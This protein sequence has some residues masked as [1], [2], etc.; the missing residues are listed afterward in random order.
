MQDPSYGVPLQLLQHVHLVCTRNFPIAHQ[1]LTQETI[2]NYLRQASQLV[3]ERAPVRWEYWQPPRDGSVFLVWQPQVQMGDN[4]ASDGYVWQEPE[5]A[6]QHS[7]GG[8]VRLPHARSRTNCGISS[9][10]DPVC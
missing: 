1:Q 3:R 4:F 9:L 8:V 10:T 6:T 5:R 2:V 7:I